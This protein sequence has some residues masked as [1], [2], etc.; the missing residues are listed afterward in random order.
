MEDHFVGKGL[1]CCKCRLL[2]KE[3]VFSCY[4]VRAQNWR[5]PWCMNVQQTSGTDWA[6]L[7]LSVLEFGN[8]QLMLFMVLAPAGPE[9]T[10]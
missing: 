8:I 6:F 4:A 3:T 1:I 2:G 9:A 7:I 5:H 10:H